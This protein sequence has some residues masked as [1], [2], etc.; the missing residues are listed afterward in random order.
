MNLWKIFWF[1]KFKK[2]KLKIHQTPFSRDKLNSEKMTRI[3]GVVPKKE[4]S[5]KIAPNSSNNE[6][7]IFFF[8]FPLFQLTSPKSAKIRLKTSPGRCCFAASVPASIF[9]SFC[10]LKIVILIRIVRNMH[11]LTGNRSNFWYWPKT[12]GLC[13]NYDF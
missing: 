4:V 5:T 3:K 2:L 6:F 10:I 7:F 12:C 8:N 9:H 1:F 13:Q 11:R